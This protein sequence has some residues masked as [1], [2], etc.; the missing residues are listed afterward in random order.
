MTIVAHGPRGSASNRRHQLDRAAE[1]L[2][3]V[4]ISP[5]PLG[6][7]PHQLSGGSA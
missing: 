6:S 7:F 4:G 3:M 2:D 5:D 1:L